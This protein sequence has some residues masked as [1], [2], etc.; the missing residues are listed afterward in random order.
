MGPVTFVRG[1]VARLTGVGMA[2]TAAA[3]SFTTVLGLVPLFTVAFVYIAR[4]PLFQQ[5]LDA[6]ERGG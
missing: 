6:L 1:V 3:L 5:W 4:Y 2:R